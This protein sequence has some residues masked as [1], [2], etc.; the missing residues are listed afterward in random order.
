M[1][2]WITNRKS[3]APDQS[4]SLRSPWVQ[5]FRS[6]TRRAHFFPANHRWYARTYHLTSSAVKFAML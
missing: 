6:G 5:A 4:A 2:T 3:Q 1:G